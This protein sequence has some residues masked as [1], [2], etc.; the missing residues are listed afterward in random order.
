MNNSLVQYLLKSAELSPEKLAIISDQG[1]ISYQD[2]KESSVRLAHYLQQN[3]VKRGDRVVICLK[4]SIET[5]IG[6]WAVLMADAVVSIIDYKQSPEK[7]K[8]ILEDS[9]ASA[10]IS[11]DS[12]IYEAASEVLCIP[13]DD[14]QNGFAAVIQKA[15]PLPMRSKHLDID[16]ASIIYTSGSTGEPKGVML[17]HRNM[18]AASHSINSYLE[19]TANERVI[20]VLPLSFDYG[21]YQM[22][23]MIA[24]GG[25]L[26]LE[27]DF[28]LPS[29]FLKRIEQFQ[30]TA[31]PVVPSM[32]PLLKQFQALKAY[33][34]SSVR[35]VT[36]TGAALMKEHIQ[37]LKQLFTAAQVFSM[38]GL[39]EC[40]RCTYLPP[41][42]IERKPESVGIAIPNTEMW[43]I[44]E[45]G[46][47]AKPNE[48]GEIVVRGQ[49]VMKGYWNK[50]EA[51]AKKLK[52]GPV[53]GEMIL[54]TGDYGRMDEE[55]YF[56]FYGRMDEVIKSRGMKVSPREIEAAIIK[57][58]SVIEVAAVPV[59]HDQY[60]QAIV[61][62]VSLEKHQDLAEIQELCKTRL[63]AHQQ[64]LDIYSINSLPKTSNGKIDKRHLA[65]EY[66]AQR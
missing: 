26:I 35:Y 54:H 17:T 49:T 42:D 55:G 12:S 6:F 11:A 46:A 2:L 31:V 51:T 32:V 47:R 66:Q 56:Y 60:G 24:V 65:N 50:P 30:A 16:L 14:S 37:S 4:N 48:L 1:E 22:I 38:Y 57:H 9:G 62:Y 13:V 3:G 53:P 18:L 39:T 45:S 41:E 33:D 27:S 25:T 10:L 40:K 15:R 29:R 19:N 28:V 59:A 8:Y 23:M 44:D 21:L 63:Q 43:V 34:L 7:V 58:P 5:V 61:L 52:A 36:N 20:S 64:P